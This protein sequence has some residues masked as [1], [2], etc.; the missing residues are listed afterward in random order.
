MSGLGLPY[1]NSMRRTY[2]PQPPRHFPRKLRWP[3]PSRARTAFLH[4][5]V[6]LVILLL[7][8]PLTFYALRSTQK[9]TEQQDSCYDAACAT[10]NVDR[11]REN[12]AYQQELS[13]ASTT[14]TTTAVPQPHRVAVTPLV[15]SLIKSATEW[16]PRNHAGTKSRPAGAERGAVLRGRGGVDFRDFFDSRLDSYYA[17]GAPSEDQADAPQT[18][19]EEQFLARLLQETQRPSSSA[20]AAG[21]ES[22]GTP[23]RWAELYTSQP[24]TGTSAATLHQAIQPNRLIGFIAWQSTTREDLLISIAPRHDRV[25]I[26]GVTYS[27]SSG[28]SSSAAEIR[29]DGEPASTTAFTIASLWA[30]ASIRDGDGRNQSAWVVGVVSGDLLGRGS[31]DTL[32]QC[33]DGSL[34]MIPH[35][36]E[37]HS[38]ELVPVVVTTTDPT[39]STLALKHPEEPSITSASITAA[40]PSHD[41][42]DARHYKGTAGRG[43]L[44]TTVS[45]AA[46][47]LYV[48][49][50]GSL[51]LLT[52]TGESVP[53]CGEPSRLLYEATS[54][55]PGLVPGSREVLPH[56]IVQGDINGDCVGELVY[57]VRDDR[58]Q[59]LEWYTLLPPPL[60][61]TSYTKPHHSPGSSS[62]PPSHKPS[63]RHRRGEGEGDWTA[64]WWS[65]P[66]PAD[67]QQRDDASPHSVVQH[68][69]LLQLSEAAVWFGN[70]TLA[71]IDGDGVV[72]LVLPY[73]TRGT[74]DNHRE[75]AGP[76]RCEGVEGVQVWLSPTNIR[77]PVSS[78]RSTIAAAC[79]P[80]RPRGSPPPPPRY[81]T[82]RV[83]PITRATCG[84]EL[85]EPSL[86]PSHDAPPHSSVPFLVRAADVDRDGRADLLLASDVGPLLLRSITASPSSSSPTPSSSSGEEPREEHQEEEVVL[87]PRE[88]WLRHASANGLSFQCSPVDA[89]KASRLFQHLHLGGRL[90]ADLLWYRDA[91]PFYMSG[92]QPG[93]MYVALSHLSLG[94]IEGDGKMRS[95]SSASS[96][97]GAVPW[98]TLYEP[99]DRY[100]EHYYILLN[101]V[102]RPTASDGSH[103]APSLG[104]VHHLYWHDANMKPQETFAMQITRGSG[105]ALHPFTVLVGL[106]KTSSYV[107]HYMVGRRWFSMAALRQ[108]A[109]AGGEQEVAEQLL[110][111]TAVSPP[112]A[113]LAVQ[114][115]TREWPSFLVPNSHVLVL[116][117]SSPDSRSTPSVSLLAAVEEAAGP[118][119]WRLS[120]HMPVQKYRRRLLTAMLIS[121]TLIGLP[122]AYMM[123][124]E[125]V[126]DIREWR[127]R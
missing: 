7:M 28:G 37:S 36:S 108:A 15:S 116:L 119:H 26:V 91:T 73:C 23:P 9:G 109:G 1:L 56:S 121:L 11:G 92:S 78:D 103:A 57:G 39:V 67:E 126:M 81:E 8:V 102:S 74:Q 71:D 120:L 27:S 31:V 89:V 77:A 18:T 97:D 47:L 53:E 19:E 66:F 55:V 22:V 52:L 40:S 3:P 30:S 70:P 33:S 34:Y 86:L 38:D 13:P 83:F 94:G 12:I 17:A 25:S 46:N 49:A 48:N 14:T 51:L 60:H 44:H 113:V 6:S 124:W 118:Q 54:L 76:L 5:I 4:V 122:V 123:W 79:L 87:S 58:H 114:W 59:T 99:A 90:P 2:S 29:E 111:P 21:E 100:M 107:H 80:S 45:P 82:S 112:S 127:E 43:V 61:S 85:G 105:I 32:L 110:P 68:H 115:M 35:H 24:T 42:A 84:L 16:G 69:R 95:G 93:Q 41:V 50:E 62:R 96:A 98:L 117:S 72:D 64:E 101:A 65:S 106:G 10:T 88:T 20:A 125:W 63:A 75:T 104:L